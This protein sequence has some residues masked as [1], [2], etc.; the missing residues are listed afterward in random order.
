MPV[1]YPVWER[2][3]VKT[4]SGDARKSNANVKNPNTVDG[5]AASVVAAAL[6]IGGV[7]LSAI[8]YGRRR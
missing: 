4:N 3:S 1:F 6:A 2:S 8:K 7:V 5:V